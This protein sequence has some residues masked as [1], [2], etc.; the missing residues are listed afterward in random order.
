MGC[1][2]LWRDGMP[3]QRSE[4]GR[5]PGGTEAAL[6]SEDRR[7]QSA[8]RGEGNILEEGTGCAQR[9]EPREHRSLKAPWV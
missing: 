6:E 8:K 1:D 3:W 4:N 9:W 7:S 2:S 5:G